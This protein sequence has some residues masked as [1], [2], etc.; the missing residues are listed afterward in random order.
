MKL[1]FIMCGNHTDAFLS[2]AAIYRMALDSLG[3][4]YAAAR[5][6][7]C[8]GGPQKVP[9]PPRW[10]D[11]FRNIEIHWVHGQ[12]YAPDDLA[13]SDLTYRMIDPSADLSVICDADTLLISPFPAD[14]LNQ[15]REDPALVGCIAH[16]PPPLR[17]FRN[18]APESIP[19]MATLWARLAQRLQV[20][21]PRLDYRYSLAQSEERCPFYI[22]LGFFAGP[23]LALIDF[24]RHHRRII[25]VVRDILEND[26][27][28]QISLPFAASAVGLA[29]RELPIRYNFP[30]DPLADRLYPDDL[31]AI[32]IL[33]YLRR[34]HFD[35]HRIF[36]DPNAFAAFMALDLEGSNAVF[37]SAVR[38]ITGGSFPF[39]A[40]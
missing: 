11:A 28:E 3:G 40:A 31:A 24:H 36:H 16:F 22:N 29:V 37:Q 20:A 32:H 26:F 5:L 18:P 15:M 35:R 17:D 1:E 9:L 39:P 38:R 25:T 27:Y 12:D 2:Q 19:N 33:H 34:K 10:Q 30:N 23:P 13:Q 21:M 7:L 14:F 6:V 8:I 4:D